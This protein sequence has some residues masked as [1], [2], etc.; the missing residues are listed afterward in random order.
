MRALALGVWLAALWLGTP[1][2]AQGSAGPVHVRVAVYLVS[3]GRLDTAN[4]TFTADFYLSFRCDRPCD[5]QDFEFTNGRATALDRQ[6]NTPTRQDY[7][8]FATLQDNFDLRRYPFDRH[9]L[10]ID[11]EHKTLDGRQ[12]V[13]TPDP[14][15]SGVSPDVV[16]TGWEL[17]P[18]WQTA[19]TDRH[20]PT[21]EE[22]YSHFRF[23][24][25]IRRATLAAVLKT[26]LPSLIIT[27][28]GF[29]ALLLHAP[30]KAQARTAA[31]GSALVGTVLFHLNMTSSIPPVGYLTFADRFSLINY[32]GLFVGLASSVWM[33]I[34]DSRKRAVREVLLQR[35]DR[36]SHFFL[37]FTPLLWVGLHLLNLTLP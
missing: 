15:H 29:L 30:E 34:E 5:A 18:G 33:L 22:D 2:L 28:S 17:V 23:S 8:V 13:Y 7:R 6:L 3:L 36:V 35:V 9:V 27:L 21:F 26:L 32:L 10:S 14:Q 12:L 4:G 19:V 20:L 31:L 16:L 37:W 11:L 25:T 1:G 24:V